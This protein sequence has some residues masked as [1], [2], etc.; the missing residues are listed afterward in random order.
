[1]LEAYAA[2]PEAFTSTLA[3]RERLPLSWWAAR[4]SVDHAAKRFVLG[5]FDG[6]ELAGAVGLSFDRREKAR[7]KATLFGM[8]VRPRW[9]RR[10][11]GRQLVLSALAHARERPGIILIQLTVTETNAPA[12]ALYESCGFLRFG[13]EPLAL[14]V[15]S[16][17]VAKV[18][19][20]RR[21][22][23]DEQGE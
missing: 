1:M 7:H 10:G 21:I 3:E 4:V 9:Q 16:Q 13:V 12:V 11:I 8:Y 18:Y 5:A 17:H 14:A 6:T 19:M 2:N 15:G 22:A 20:W 23:S